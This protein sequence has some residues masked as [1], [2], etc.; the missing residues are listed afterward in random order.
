MTETIKLS[1]TCGAVEMEAR[2]PRAVQ[3]WSYAPV[4]QGVV[5]V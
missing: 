4:S 2:S 1:C 3:F 5:R